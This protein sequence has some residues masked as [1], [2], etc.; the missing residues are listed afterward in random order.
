[1]SP[2]AAA[3]VRRKVLGIK[4]IAG[5]KQRVEAPYAAEARGEGDVGELEGG[6]AEQPLGEQQPLRLRELDRRHPSSASVTRRKCRS[7]TPREAARSPTRPFETACSSM[8]ATAAQPDGSWHRDQRVRERA[9][10]GSA[11]RA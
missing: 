1:M 5:F 3:A 6:L 11:G 8:P 4:P 2:C 7:L 9:P 10:A